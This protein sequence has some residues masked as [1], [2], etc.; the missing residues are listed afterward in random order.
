MLREVINFFIH[1]LSVSKFLETILFE[2][3]TKNMTLHPDTRHDWLPLKSLKLSFN[4]ILLISRIVLFIQT[5][6]FFIA[7]NHSVNKNIFFLIYSMS[8][9]ILFLLYNVET[10]NIKLQN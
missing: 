6:Y 10:R 3:S 7:L 4:D 5:A 9:L 8:V 1:F 2:V